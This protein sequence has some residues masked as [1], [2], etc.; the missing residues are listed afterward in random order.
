M[1]DFYLLNVSGV[2]S[3][4]ALSKQF[5]SMKIF[6]IRKSELY[7]FAEY[8]HL[9]PAMDEEGKRLDAYSKEFLSEAIRRVN[10]LQQ[11]NEMPLYPTE[12][13]IWDENIVP[14][15]HYS[16]E[17]VLALNKLNLQ[18]LTLHDYLLRNFNLFQLESTYEIRQDIEDVLF[19]MKPWRHEA[20]NETVWSGWARMA[21]P[22]DDHIL[23]NCHKT[24]YLA[25]EI[26]VSYL[27]SSQ[28]GNMGW[29]FGIKNIFVHMML[30]VVFLA[31]RKHDVCFLVTCRATAPVVA[32][33]MQYYQ[34]GQ[35]IE[36]YGESNSFFNKKCNQ[37]LEIGRLKRCLLEGKVTRKDQFMIQAKKHQI[38]TLKQDKVALNEDDKKSLK[39]LFVAINLT[40]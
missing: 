10:Q 20:K 31:L 9:V 23:F 35:V 26:I 1:P 25:I 21:L 14:Y 18:F 33:L 27:F 36:E 24:I 6:D 28:N 15:E 2:D 30:F 38:Y 11:L 8:L 19:R 4:R 39:E 22:L 3:R 29:R 5:G 12:Q 37:N 16:G 34:T 32:Y 17:G 7:R 13:V 40:R